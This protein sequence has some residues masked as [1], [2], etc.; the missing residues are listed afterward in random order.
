M[1]GLPK[2]ERRFAPPGKSQPV[3]LCCVH[4]VGSAT[5][6]AAHAASA[7]QLFERHPPTEVGQDS[8]KTGGTTLG[9]L[10]LKV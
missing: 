4:E 5:G 8:S 10:E 2:L 3:I 7:P 1:G 9:R 6:V